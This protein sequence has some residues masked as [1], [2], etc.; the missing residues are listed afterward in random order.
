M[1]FTISMVSIFKDLTAFAK[2]KF[3][4]KDWVNNTFR[5]TEALSNPEVCFTFRFSL[6]FI[7]KC[8]FHFRRIL[9]LQL[10]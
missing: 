6:E 1:L 10:L 7:I 2:E 8:L 9:R 3:S 5:Q 4:A